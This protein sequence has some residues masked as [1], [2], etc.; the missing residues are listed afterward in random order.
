VLTASFILLARYV[1]TMSGIEETTAANWY[2]CLNS[3]KSS[4]KAFTLSSN[5]NTESKVR[6]V[7]RVVLRTIVSV[8]TG[9][10]CRGW[11]R[12]TGG[13][14]I[15]VAKEGGISTFVETRTSTRE[16]DSVFRL[17]MESIRVSG[18]GLSMFKMKSDDTEELCC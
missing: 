4:S 5:L 12:E 15:V 11:M 1:S 8:E 6:R 14:G 9:I 13:G 16:V 10:C 7:Y 17:R 3:E 2:V 18:L